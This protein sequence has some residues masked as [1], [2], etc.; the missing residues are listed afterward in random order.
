VMRA[1]ALKKCP[2]LKGYSPRVPHRDVHPEDD[3]D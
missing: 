1:A 3:Q 2:S